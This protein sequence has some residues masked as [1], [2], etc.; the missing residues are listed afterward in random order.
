M[1]ELRQSRGVLPCWPS[2]GGEGGPQ[3]PAH[4]GEEQ[5]GR[6]SAS[7]RL[8]G[9]TAEPLPGD[10]HP[11]HRP[12]GRCRDLG[13]PCRGMCSLHTR[14]LEPGAGVCGR[15]WSPWGSRAGYIPGLSGVP[16]VGTSCPVAASLL[17]WPVCLCLPSSPYQ[18]PTLNQ[19][20]VFPSPSASGCDPGVRG[21]WGP[22]FNPR[23]CGTWT[24][25]LW[26]G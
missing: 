12:R 25:L 17:L 8:S 6:L 9:L 20:G 21:S 4:L 7:R 22:L 10:P 14:S 1:V 23:D 11:H 18:D 26:R 13:L 15:S 16:R 5:T 2:S 19:G 3:V 24:W